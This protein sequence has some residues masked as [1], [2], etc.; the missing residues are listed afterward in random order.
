MLSIDDRIGSGELL[1][2]FKTY[3]IKVQKTRLEFGDMCWT[4]NGP[5]GECVVAVERKKIL[6]LVQS[7]QSRRLS[8][9][10]LPGM[11]NAY[12]Y[13]YLLVEGFWGPDDDGR[14]L[15]NKQP[16]SL[17][18][19]ALDAYLTTLEVKAGLIYR[20]TISAAETV[21]CVV[22][23]YRWWTEKTWDEHTAHEAVYAPADGNNGRKM[24]F[25]PREVSGSEK[26]LMQLPGVDAGAQQLA[27]RFKVPNDIGLVAREDWPEIKIRDKSGKFKRIGEMRAERIWRFWHG[28]HER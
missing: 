7:M 8:G 22:D 26:V 10:Q 28:I 19:R 17:S 2:M 21:A 5:C 20:R 9:H 15:V 24:L 11:A 14:L 12:D 1:E 16:Q 18:Y 6:D 13:A 3:G 4:G 25:K 23:L 27:K